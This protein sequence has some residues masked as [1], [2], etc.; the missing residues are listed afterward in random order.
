VGEEFAVVCLEAVRDETERARLAGRLAQSGREI[1]TLNLQQMRRFA[2]NLLQLATGDGSRVIVL[3]A[4][5]R[6]AL[7]G[8]QT[9]LLS[10]H[11]RLLPV[12]IPTI[13][14]AG[15]GSVRC[16]L[17]ENFLPHAGETAE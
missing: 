3:S 17:A 11:G 1:V 16:M 14:A 5:A 2:G 9:R 8:E 12:A 4:T 7:R 15:G 10:R 6:L 13:E